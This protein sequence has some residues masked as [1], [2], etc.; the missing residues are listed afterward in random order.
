MRAGISSEQRVPARSLGLCLLAIVSFAAP[1][2]A[3]GGSSPRRVS[4]R[5]G[6]RLD[7]LHQLAASGSTLHLAHARLGDGSKLDRVV[8]QRSRDGGSDWT[9][10]HV[11]FTSGTG[12]SQVVPNLA[13]A[14]RG[15]IV[16]VAFR[17]QGRRGTT[18]FVRTSRDGG[19]RFGPRVAVATRSA[20]H[21]LGVPAITVGGDVIAVAWTE[22]GDGSIMLKR[23][24]DGGRSFSRVTRVG[25]TRVSIECRGRVTDGLVGLVAAGDRLH[26][27]WSD[28]KDRSCIAGRIV[29]RTSP[30]RGRRWREERVV[31]DSRSYGWPELAASGDRVV[32]TVQLPSGRLL[33][34][35]SRDEG[36]SWRQ[37]TLA[38]RRGRT[39]SAGD[40]LI[41][42]RG[43]VWVGYVEE[44]IANSRL[45]ETRVRVRPSR[46]GGAT[47]GK[48]RT[49]VGVSRA[50]RQAVNIVDTDTGRVAVFQSGSFSGK[51][52]NLLVSR[53]R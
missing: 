1:A 9:R 50:L 34:A 8:V 12:Y 6:S 39:L 31:T 38:P 4:E 18:L 30:D 17:A 26:L 35:R 40:I 43:Q 5:A 25:G 46:D 45:R 28:A 11:L 21:A 19:R 42:R 48:A 7:S 51:P 20:K 36:R 44:R 53:W 37:T 47:F 52:R 23:S 33:V 2:L 24:R 29:M 13:I 10:E 3:D 41:R 49:L 22:R 15:S 14:S 16:A 32:A 27:A